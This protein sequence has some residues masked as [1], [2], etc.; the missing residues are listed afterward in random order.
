MQS[1]NSYWI[2]GSQVLWKKN[3]Q[4]HPYDEKITPALIN[5]QFISSHL[6]YR[7]VTYIK[8]HIELKA[9][10]FCKDRTP[11][12][13]SQVG[14]ITSALASMPLKARYTSITFIV[15][16]CERERLDMYVFDFRLYRLEH[17]QYFYSYTT[18]WLSMRLC[19]HI[20][21]GIYRRFS[22]LIHMSSQLG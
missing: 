15:N 18:V 17:L 7:Y 6:K 13:R 16:N 11:T 12:N 9:V 14:W 20:L 22:S 10:D 2:K 3:L 5:L 1:Q 21:I 8:I 4:L 19:S